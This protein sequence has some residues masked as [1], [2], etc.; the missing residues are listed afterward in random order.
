[1]I[2]YTK[3]PRS[4]EY[5]PPQSAAILSATQVNIVAWVVQVFLAIAFVLH[6]I[7]YLASP[8][9]LTRLM[10]K[11]P[12]RIPIWLRQF[13]GV[14]EILA[15]IAL[16]G[17]AWTHILPW[18]TPLAALGLGLLMA[19]AAVYHIRLKESPVPVLVLM[20]LAVALVYLRWQVSPIT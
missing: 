10:Q 20:V 6:G 19:C 9:P 12:P 13:I 3:S 18:L 1:M 11:W 8:E 4:P 14:V 2:S 17:P 7:T 16:I 15:A 5:L